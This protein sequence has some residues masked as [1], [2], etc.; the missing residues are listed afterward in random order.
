VSQP[1]GVKVSKTAEDVTRKF[2]FLQ[3]Y[4]R[5]LLQQ[6]LETHLEGFE[7]KF[8]DKFR[9]PRCQADWFQNVGM[10]ERSPS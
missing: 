5:A 3:C 1:L 7:H 2:Q 4:E 9:R 10:V 8:R 6:I